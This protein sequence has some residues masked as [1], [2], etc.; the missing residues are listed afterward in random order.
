MHREQNY[1]RP[2]DTIRRQETTSGGNGMNC[3]I[4]DVALL[5]LVLFLVT[6]IATAQPAV[7][8]S[9]LNSG[10]L[11]A[12]TTAAAGTA[13]GPT[14]KAPVAGK[15]WDGLIQS[16]T[17]YQSRVPNVSAPPNPQIAVGPDDILT[18]VN[19]TIARYP[20]PNASGNALVTTPYNYPPTEWQFLDIWTGASAGSGGSTQGFIDPTVLC[21]SG[22]GSNTTCVIDNATI[23]YDQM[24]GRFVVLFTVTD[25]PAHRSNFVLIVSKFS[26]FTKCSAATPSCPTSSPLF[27]PPVIAPIVGGTQTGG[28]ATSNWYAYVIPVN[29]LYTTQPTSLGTGVVGVK[30][31]V[32]TGG[33][34]VSNFDTTFYCANGG[35]SL[36][37]VSTAGG[38]AFSCTDYF[39][40]GARLGFDNDN[41]I[42]AAPVLD[43]MG[44]TTQ[45]TVVSGSTNTQT[46]GPYVGTRLLALAK[47]VVY[48]GT[49]LSL[50]SG[51][52]PPSC[53]GNTPATCNAVNLSDNLRT[54]TLTELVTASN[55][56]PGNTTAGCNTDINAGTG[57]LGTCAPTSSLSVGFGGIPSW[58]GR[59]FNV[60]REGGHGCSTMPPIFWE[61]DN[62]RG[63]AL[64]S[65]DAE[66][67][68]AGT[69]V[70]GVISPIDYIVGTLINNNVET[71]AGNGTIGTIY[72]AQP[73]VFS[74]PGTNGAGGVNGL[75]GLSFCLS[76]GSQVP[77]LPVLA[78]V[79]TTASTKEAVFDPQTVG[80]G[81]SASSMTTAPTVTPVSPT[82]QKRLFVGDSRPQ[83]VMFREGLLYVARD[84]QSFTLT[85]QV[86]GSSTVLYNIIKTCDVPT[87]GAVPA[88]P[89]PANALAAVTG[90][91]LQPNV[92]SFD[93]IYE[94]EWFNL[95]QV[96]LCPTSNGACDPNGFGFYTPMFDSPADVI[97][98]GPASPSAGAFPFLEKLFVGMTTGGTGNLATTFSKNF[99]SLWDIRPGDDAFDTSEPYTDPY[100]GDLLTTVACP[101]NITYSATIT[102]GSKTATITSTVGLSAGL[103]V[104]SPIAA[105]STSGTGFVTGTTIT[106]LGSNSITLSNGATVPGGSTCNSAGTNAGSGT[107]ACMTNVALT[108]SNTPPNVTILASLITPG[109]N[110]FT[111]SSSTTNL[112]IGSALQAT[113]TVNHNSVNPVPGPTNP[114]TAGTLGGGDGTIFSAAAGLT[115]LPIDSLT[116]VGLGETV[117]GGA[118][119]PVAAAENTGSLIIT[120]PAVQSN[121]Q[122]LF[123]APG[124]TVTGTGIAAATTVASVTAVPGGAAATT[125]WL[126]TLSAAATATSTTNTV[127]FSA[128]GLIATGTTVINTAVLNSGAGNVN[129]AILSAGVLAPGLP[130]G[131]VITFTS[132]GNSF[133]PGGTVIS[134][135]CATGSAGC[136]AAPGGGSTTIVLS[137]TAFNPQGGL[138]EILDTNPTGSCSNVPLIFSTGA[139]GSLSAPTCPMIQW[140]QHGGAST[141]PNDGSLWLYGEF[142]KFRLATI[143]GPG[144][145]G[146]SVANYELDFPAIDVY[147]NDNAY[148]A[149]YQPG[150]QFFIWV[151]IAKNA[152]LAQVAEV[153]PVNGACPAGTGNQIVAPPIAGGTTGSGTSTLQCPY[154]F[155]GSTVTRSEMARWVVLA[156]MDEQQIDNFLCATGGTPIAPP[157]GVV[158]PAGCLVG[159]TAS[160]VHFADTV[161]DPNLRYIEVMFRRGYSNGCSNT[162][163]VMANFCPTANV[164][165]GEMAAMVIRAKMSNVF[166]ASLSGAPVGVVSPYGDNFAIFNPAPYFSDEPTTDVFYRYIQVMR[167][168]RITNGVTG[169]TYGGGTNITREQM[170]TFIVRAFFL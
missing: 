124:E 43:Q 61:P 160:T 12:S 102:Q 30:N 41:I 128:A 151:Q 48:N 78:N 40:T 138:C 75:A 67:S 70:A 3:R 170:A 158:D 121:G 154:F 111:T 13:G 101:G 166:P 103:F 50:G 137:Q 92:V 106:A 36:P 107:S 22:Y 79:I 7:K 72:F 83:Q 93:T 31:S 5:L 87:S 24:Q 65:Y 2:G 95:S 51:D 144:Q 20:N 64:A 94:T 82:T 55:L 88:C 4:R 117:S 127:T 136:P 150:S 98:T 91:N 23:R 108:F 57:V 153:P 9:R 58:C 69:A 62:L 104:T 52:Q 97:G 113:F 149:D 37:L 133:F 140:S 164:T 28:V 134:N 77:D 80:Q 53:T 45:G 142:A 157:A 74:C 147:N 47:L 109:S 89:G 49:A 8:V 26:Q 132:S 115:N 60:T 85:G 17:D 25:I 29:L 86:F 33:A 155:P 148:F 152:G 38:N 32:A 68:P 11:V 99:P 118:S 130:I 162:N 165:R 120:V 112:T 139:N 16:S 114:P 10:A 146:T 90:A 46:M 126:V 63:P 1:A 159:G 14:A 81:F 71:G 125:S 39:P 135:I 96:P 116:N 143:P 19:R 44:A 59:N 76:S 119:L 141:D 122:P 54:G 73:V 131:R 35:P 105:S 129:E 145:W 21:P 15:Y 42:I 123:I 163:T 66:V 161:T 110:A 27:T 168:L 100:T 84:V 169:T 6:G 56:L 167:E 34:T 156:Q 18:L